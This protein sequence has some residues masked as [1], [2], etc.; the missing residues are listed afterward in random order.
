[1][2]WSF[3]DGNISSSNNPVH[4]YNTTGDFEVT[5]TITA[6]GRTHTLTKTVS[7]SNLNIDDNNLSNIRIHPNPTKNHITIK[8]INTK[9]YSATLYSILGQKI[10]SFDTITNNTI[11]LSDIEQGTYFLEIVF[12]NTKEI[13][14]I[15]KQ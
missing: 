11:S 6:C 14:K 4:T 13:K 8:A 10:K 15:I 2:S 5:L 12:N 9:D 3:G 7:V 1:V